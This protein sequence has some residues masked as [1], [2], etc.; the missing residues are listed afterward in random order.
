VRKAQ[1]AVV[2]HVSNATDYEGQPFDRGTETE[3]IQILTA[4]CRAGLAVAKAS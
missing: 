2:A 4:I 3:G 1:I